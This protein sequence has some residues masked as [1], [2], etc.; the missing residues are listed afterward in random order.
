M[1]EKLE[2]WII[3]KDKFSGAFGK[4]KSALPSVK[5]MA[6]ATTAAVAGLGTALYAM[7]TKTADTYDKVQKLSD[8]LGVTTEFLSKMQT[9]A[10]FAGIQETT[11]NKA[12]QMT[13]VRIGEAARGIGEGKEA[14]QTLGVQLTDTSGK[15]KTA[16][17]IMP[18]LAGAFNDMT[19]ATEKAELASKI[20]GQRGMSMLQMFK[21]GEEGL[22][23]MTDEAERFGLVVSAKAGANAA[24]FNDS[25]TR[26]KM[27]LTGL[28]N[29]IAEEVMPTIT[30]LSNRFANFVVNNRE[31][32]I[33][34]GEKFLT[35]MAGI[36]E[37]GVYGVALL[38]DSWRGLQMTWE[39]LKV[40]FDELS[41]LLWQ[42][43]DTLT[44][45]IISL[46]ETFNF[47]GIF[48]SQIESIQNFS[49]VTKAVILDVE[50]ASAE[51]KARLEEIADQGLATDKVTEYADKIK[52]TF[53]EIRGEGDV[54][55]PPFHQANIDKTLENIETTKAITQE[56]QDALNE[57]WNEYMLSDLER[58]DIWYAEQQAKYKNNQEAQTKLYDI[59][60]KKRAKISDIE[61]K[62]EQT[63]EQKA[64]ASK[65]AFYGYVQSAAKSH[66]STMLAAQ[67]I[68]SVVTTIQETSAASMGAYEALA[69]IP[70]IGPAL[71]AAAAAMVYAY[72]G[73]R[74][75]E[76]R[77]QPTS[78][79]HGG[80]GYTPKEQTY[81]LDKGERVLSPNQNKDFTDFMQNGGG[82]IQQTNHFE[83]LPNATNLQAMLDMDRRDWEEVCTDKIIPALK[84][85]RTQGVTV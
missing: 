21:D 42:G 2:I 70:I 57:M 45:K 67:K 4:L 62:R 64:K 79:A 82:S 16:E 48:D 84:I 27:S 60:T 65:D 30:G 28:R 44:Q 50:T 31:G 69:W 29:K 61:L 37:K 15:L 74:I 51:S 40:G 85:L 25:L 76:I 12:I 34:F 75:N 17:Q 80:I 22:S 1:A 23:K 59:Y 49:A 36:T 68:Q 9:A 13:Q 47:G 72:G 18:E 55:I 53:A 58:L 14:F 33:D 24:E 73:M 3:G 77:S 11:L 56:A 39:L 81:L 54:G 7:T 63:N 38:V 19:S 78:I 20:F 26:T 43:I 35:V 83:I 52:E 5:V 66:G 10:Q 41:S 46:L 32:I 71:G 8:Q 6:V